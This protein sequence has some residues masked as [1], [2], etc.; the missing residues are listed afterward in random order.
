VDHRRQLASRKVVALVQLLAYPHA[1]VWHAVLN[2]L[3]SF[4]ELQWE[5]ESDPQTQQRV[6]AAAAVYKG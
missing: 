2:H 6:Q 4:E 1:Q 3:D 5:A